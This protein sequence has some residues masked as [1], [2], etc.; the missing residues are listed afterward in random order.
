MTIPIHEGD[1]LVI[2]VA[3]TEQTSGNPKNITG[4]TIDAVAADIHGTTVAATDAITD[5]AD[6]K[7]TATFS[8]GQLVTGKWTFQARV[9]LGSETQ[10][11]AEEIIQVS[12][13]YA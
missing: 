6:G 3:V 9:E 4:A 5:A 7:F 11:V 2:L 13:G 1:T 10:V 8:A 12:P